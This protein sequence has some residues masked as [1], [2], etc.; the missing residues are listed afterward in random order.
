MKFGK[1]LLVNAGAMPLGRLLLQ[2]LDV[3]A[4]LLKSPKLL[5]HPLLHLHLHLLPKQKHQSLHQHQH[6]PP[7]QRQPLCRPRSPTLQMHS[8]ILISLC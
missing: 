6:L 3:M 1:T 7:H 5:Q 8:L 2:L 4:R